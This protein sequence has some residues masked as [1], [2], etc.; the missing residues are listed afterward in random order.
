[1]GL[2]LA[3]L[4]LLEA[5][6]TL[7]GAGHGIAKEPL[8]LFPYQATQATR[9]AVLSLVMLWIRVR[10]GPNFVRARKD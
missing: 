4:Y 9:Y 8:G 10:N 6:D 3:E 2:Y 1:V 7:N 5:P